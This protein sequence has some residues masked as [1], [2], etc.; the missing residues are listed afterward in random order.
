MT[1]SAKVKLCAS[2]LVAATV[3]LAAFDTSAHDV[4]G[5]YSTIY[6]G[7][8]ILPSTNLTE[9]RSGS[10][11]STGRARF[12]SGFGAGGAFGYRYGN[13][14]AA[15]IAFDYR[16]HSLNRLGGASVEGD[17][18]SKTLFLNGYYRFAKWGV[19]RPFA[20]AGV[21]WTQEIDLDIKRDGRAISYSRSGALALQGILGGEV[22]LSERWSLVG[23][24][25][26]MQ[27]GSGR[28]KTETQGTGGAISG[29]LGYS[30]ISANFGLSYRF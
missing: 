13:G 8:S 23:D 15:E 16:S 5:F 1:M 21:G 9:T 22:E 11:T 6:V 7:P 25:R 18:A 2:F 17:F 26:V 24:L 12:D 14:L 10:T 30:P 29:N 27:I 3:T 28:F 19:V 20:G 4:S